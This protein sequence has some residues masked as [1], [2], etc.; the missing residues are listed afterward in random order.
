MSVTF[1]L[2]AVGH[3]VSV[4]AFLALVG[5]DVAQATSW[6]STLGFPSQGVGTTSAVETVLVKNSLP[7][8]LPFGG[9]T[10]SGDYAVTTAPSNP[11]GATI[12]AGASCSIG[13]TFTPTQLGA[14]SGTLAVSAPPMESPFIVILKGKG[15][16]TSLSEMVLTPMDATIAAGALQQFGATG[17]F[18][19]DIKLDLTTLVRWRSSSTAVAI[20]SN[21]RG[22]RGLAIGRA[23]GITTISASLGSAVSSSTTL[24]VGAAITPTATAAA[25]DTPTGTPT[26]TAT[27]TAVPFLQQL[28]TCCLASESTSDCTYVPGSC[29]CFLVAYDCTPPI[30]VIAPIGYP[31]PNLPPVGAAAPPP[32]LGSAAFCDY[33]YC[34]F[35][36]GI[37]DWTSSARM[38]PGGATPPPP[39]DI[40]PGM[41]APDPATP[42]DPTVNY[43]D[44]YYCYETVDNPI[45]WH[46]V[47]RWGSES[48]TPTNFTS[49][50]YCDRNYCFTFS[51]GQWNFAPIDPNA[52][53]LPPAVAPPANIP[54]PSSVPNDTPLGLFCD[55]YY[56]YEPN[57]YGIWFAHYAGAT[58][59]TP[60]PSLTGTPNATPSFG[61]TFGVTPAPTD[62]PTAATPN[63]TPTFGFTFGATPAPTDIP[64]AATPN[65][66]PTFGFTFG[67]TPAPTDI[68]TA[69][70]PNVTPSF[71]FTFGA[72]PVP[73]DTPTTTPIETPS[74]GV[75]PGI[76]PG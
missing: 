41:P 72:T 73:T 63:V 39:L 45:Y 15:T 7:T 56:C 61:F 46:A 76:T 50:F 54:A 11:C 25:V 6:Q 57:H 34:Y 59:S 55:Q 24:T 3:A 27:P 29:S 4:V 37:G 58:T 68:P 36:D 32:A 70:T 38:V 12:P 20:I 18:P 60:P 9:A 5:S 48:L 51:G 30:P 69:A 14:R 13:V 64:T 74:F 31:A 75:T 26:P 42:F 28:T 33:F 52:V 53:G 65:V 23:A 19:G 16:K 49:T 10:A 17:F 44:L 71:G 21:R 22:A 66:T 8:T 47:L 43:C 67:A 1:R 62:I 35:T 2:A 40:P